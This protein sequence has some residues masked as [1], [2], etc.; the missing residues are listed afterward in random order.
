LFSFTSDNK[1]SIITIALALFAQSQ[2]DMSGSHQGGTARAFLRSL[3][4][5]IEEKKR[6]KQATKAPRLIELADGSRSGTRVSVQDFRQAVEDLADKFGLEK[7]K[8]RI[9]H[10]QRTAEL[11][12]SP[13]SA[14]SEKVF[15]HIS[16]SERLR[17]LNMR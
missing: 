2:D 13:E 9:C 6:Q 12:I 16:K 7:E 11:M 1:F 14:K 3:R 8:W 4:A 15:D 17:V 5:E 10:D